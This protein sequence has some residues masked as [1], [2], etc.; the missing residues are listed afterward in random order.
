MVTPSEAEIRNQ[1][2]RLLRRELTFEDFLEWLHSLQ[3]V[4][5]SGSPEQ[6]LLYQI[7]ARFEEYD[8]GMWNDEHMKA[9]LQGLAAV[10]EPTHSGRA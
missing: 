10:P 5:P 4:L 3:L 1:L 8:A 6:R 7:I 9:F 2:A